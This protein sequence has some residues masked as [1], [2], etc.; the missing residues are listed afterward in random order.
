VADCIDDTFYFDDYSMLNHEGASW[1]WTFENASIAS[2]TKRNPE[3]TFNDY[4]EFAVTLEVTNAQGISSTDTLYVTVSAPDYEEEISE[5]FE[6]VFPPESWQTNIQSWSY[7]N[8]VGGYGLSDN[9]MSVNN[10]INS[11]VGERFEIT[12]PVNMQNNTLE[13]SWLS[14]DLAYAEYAPNYRD[15]LEILISLD[16]GST[17]A[18]VYKKWGQELAT[19]PNTTELFIP[20]PDQWRTDSVD[21]T[22]FIGQENVLIKF[23]N[24]NG[25]GQPLYVDNVNMGGITTNLNEPT[26]SYKHLNFFPN[27][28]HKSG[29]LTISTGELESLE[30][31]IFKLSG[32]LVGNIFTQTNTP[33]NIN[34]WN[35][36]AGT[37]IIKI[38][39]KDQIQNGKLIV[40]GNRR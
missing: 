22:S 10:F 30:C 32:K 35:L 9:C 4:G 13:N 5:D 28:I 19:A 29:N 14:F 11:Q 18:S 38:Q 23:S 21:L 8:E 25:W 12:A 2:S 20:T 39:T 6:T 40:V 36:S 16:C 1:Y 34:R 15:T 7:N 17:W 27:P 26:A 31:S 24:I 33:I 3:V 37:Y